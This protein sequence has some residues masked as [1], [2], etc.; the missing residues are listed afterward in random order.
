MAKQGE[1]ATSSAGEDAASAS[2]GDEIDASAG[3]F[4]NQPGFAA[5]EWGLAELPVTEWHGLVFVDSSGSAPPLAASLGTLD[6]LIAPYEPD[7]LVVAGPQVMVGYLNR[8]GLS[9][10]GYYRVALALV[11]GLLIGHGML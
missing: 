9:L 4:K 6:E 11:A 1:A 5:G 2:I 3:G 7:R 8:H 10:F